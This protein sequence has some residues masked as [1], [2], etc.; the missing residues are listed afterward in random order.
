MF[1]SDFNVF[2]NWLAQCLLEHGAAEIAMRKIALG[3][4][5]LNRI[6]PDCRTFTD[7]N[8]W[9]IHFDLT[10]SV[11]SRGHSGTLLVRMAN[12][13]SFSEI[14]DYRYLVD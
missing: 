3:R 5:G 13:P 14:S 9:I 4:I 10:Y 6:R 2:S 1:L 8:V 12:G 7:D 11:D